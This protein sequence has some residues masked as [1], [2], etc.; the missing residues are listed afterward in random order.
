MNTIE[1]LEKLAE[2]N[3]FLETF[4]QRKNDTREL[5][6]AE[7]QAL[8]NSVLTP[9]ILAKV[10]EIKAEFE[11]KFAALESDEKYNVSK[12]A[13]SLLTDEIKAEVIQAGSTVKGSCLQAVYAKG[14]VSWDTKALDGY[15][16]GHPE[17]APFRKEGDPSV[18]IRKV[19][20]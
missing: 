3:D 12:A 5:L 8:I 18:S 14:R 10:E 15:A 19:A 4:E 20:A 7:R 2:L 17:I 6:D 16:A 1:K 9:E 11:P 13:A